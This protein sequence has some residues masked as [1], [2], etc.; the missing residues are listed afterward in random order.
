VIEIKFK[1]LN[2]LRLS[3]YPAKRRARWKSVQKVSSDIIIY[4]PRLT[5]T[6]SN[7]AILSANILYYFLGE[8]LCSCIFRGNRIKKECRDRKYKQPQ[9]VGCI[10]FYI[11]D[12]MFR[13]LF[14]LEI[15]ELKSKQKKIYEFMS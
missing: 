1:D 10:P 4:L 13:R 3:L 5:K 8:Y 14:D 11:A 6:V 7:S 15:N 12:K 9:R 2:E